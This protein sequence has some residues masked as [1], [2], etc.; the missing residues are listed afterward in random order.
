MQRRMV[1]SLL[2]NELERIWKE[3]VWLQRVIIPLFPW[4]VLGNQQRLSV[5]AASTLSEIQTGHFPNG[6]SERYR[7]NVQL[8]KAMA[9]P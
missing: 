5:R 9:A 7:Y 3:S 6:S 4:K 2:N 1:E 8:S